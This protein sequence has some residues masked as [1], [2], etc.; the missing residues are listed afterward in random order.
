M[1]ICCP[2][3]MMLLLAELSRCVHVLTFLRCLVMEIPAVVALRGPGLSCL[4]S[5][6]AREAHSFPYM[7]CSGPVCKPLLSSCLGGYSGPCGLHLHCCIAMIWHARMCAFAH[8]PT[9]LRYAYYC[10][11][12]ALVVTVAP[13]GLHLHCCLN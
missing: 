7:I 3:Y 8:G 10:C 1:Q 2:A 11:Q 9:L 6:M 12:T 13:C 5:R 4:P